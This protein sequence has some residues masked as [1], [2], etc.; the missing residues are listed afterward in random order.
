MRR[1]LL[2]LAWAALTVPTLIHAQSG[3]T[4]PAEHLAPAPR[5][6]PTSQTRTL[7]E[8]IR[9]ALAAHPRLSAA[10]R[11]V[12]ASDAA[13]LQAAAWPNPELGVEVE[14]TRSRTRTTTLQLSQPIEL[15]GKR[16]ARIAAADRTRE[17]AQ[18]QLAARRT[19]VRAAVTTAFAEA[20]IAQE[21]V[22]LSEASLQLATGAARAATQRVM[23]GKI[24]P[25]EATK[26]QVAVST[27][28]LELLRAQG[29]LRSALKL[30]AAAVGD[31]QPVER[32]EGDI[33]LPPLSA[34]TALP[35][36][37][38]LN[39]LPAYRAALLEVERLGALA[40]LARA[41][42]VPDLT[43]T[44]G[45]KRS[46]ELGRSQAVIGLSIPLPVFDT[47]RGAHVEALRRQDQARDEARALALGLEAELQHSEERLR[48][49]RAQAQTLQHDVL[50]GAQAAYDAATQGFQLGKFGFL[51]VL[52]AQRT[53]LDARAQYLRALGDAHRAAN[54]I[55]RLTGGAEELPATAVRP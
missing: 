31:G 41:R 29:E 15:G 53:L 10:S 34:P 55:E 13:R 28:R 39:R 14:D 38:R 22:R 7:A 19:E 52:D 18:L 6:A 30:L 49:T 44:V 16:S 40:D 24:S 50:P 9:H 8:A 27:V 42:R 12:E 32:V 20:L 45:A 37:E 54:D 4:P 51:D 23:A 48:T 36:A 43:V 11:E 17:I 33:E 46:E 5:P 35:L 21:R 26:A 47:H 3:S 1:S 2:P 25:I